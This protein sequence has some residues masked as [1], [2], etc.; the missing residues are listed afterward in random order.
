[1][2]GG[3]YAGRECEELARLKYVFP[4]RFEA[5]LRRVRLT[6]VELA[7]RVGVTPSTISAWANGKRLPRLPQLCLLAQGLGVKV[8]FLVD[9][10][11][12]VPEDLG[13]TDSET[14]VLHYV[15]VENGRGHEPSVSEV[16]EA[17]DGDCTRRVHRLLAF[18]LLEPAA[19]RLS[20]SGQG[21]VR[22]G[23]DEG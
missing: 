8:D 15:S 18:K 11:S 3:G 4:A 14:D 5:A 23:E 17:F 22:A 1:M 9:A 6:K 13:P 12:S 20:S 16:S 10:E 19:L 7:F 2:S 21:L